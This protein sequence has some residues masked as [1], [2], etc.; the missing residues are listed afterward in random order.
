M[1]Q[2]VL[3]IGAVAA[4]PK[5]AARFKRLEPDSTVLMIDQ[6]K[7][8]SYGSCGIPYYVGGDVSDAS[9]LRATSFHMVRDN[10]FFK[11]VK[12][13][14]VRTGLKAVQVDRAGKKVLVRN[15]DNGKEEYLPYDKLVI[16]MGA[17]VRKL[18]LPGEDLEGVHYI[19]S[20]DEAILIREALTKGLVNRAVVVG[21]GFIG[22]E[23]ADALADMWGVE[24]EVVE[25]TSQI[26][27]RLV[28]PSLAAMGQ[29]HMEEKGV[30]FHLNEKVVRLE[31]E[32]RVQR[33][34]TDRNEI[35]ADLVIMAPGVVP[36]SDLAKEAGLDV[37]ERGGV[38]VDEHMR[39]SDPDIYAGGDCVLVKN[40]ITGQPLYL[41]MGSLSNRQGRVIGTNLAGGDAVFSGAV[42]SFVVKI[43]ERTLSGAGLSLDSARA[44]GFDAGSVLMVQLDRA[45]FYPT[46]ALMTLELVYEKGTRRI[47]G[48]QGFG[49]TSDALVGRVNVVAGLLPH[50]PKV[51]EL[52][53][54]EMAYSPPFAAAVDI[55]NSLGHV[56]ENAIEGRLLGVYPDEFHRLWEGDGCYF[57]DCREEADA[58]PFLKANPEQWHNIPQGKLY[59]RIAEV[60]KDKP[61]LLVCNTGARSYEAQVQLVSKGY[62]NVQSAMGGMAGLK[63]WGEKLD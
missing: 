7:T 30:V 25:I 11:E 10:D 31:G 58:S 50:K 53:N 62:K 28:S 54:L 29:R 51:E 16:S 48:I 49:S 20:L 52:S 42:G 56:A 14:D 39:T 40:L 6:S 32:G 13:V 38:L 18:G 34:I 8:I 22:L 36:N 47:L 57:L 19:S 45:H 12:G 43:F 60:P 9:E 35:E 59:E 24:T 44:A 27:P 2:H 37:H 1:P 15:V 61:I 55:L 63:Q 46:K 4:G 3:I 5:A 21:A 17:R 23:M 41:P 26:M 33:V